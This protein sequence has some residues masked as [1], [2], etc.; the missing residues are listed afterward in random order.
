MLFN[1]REDE[2]KVN[3]SHFTCFTFQQ[4]LL[5]PK[6]ATDFRGSSQRNLFR[7]LS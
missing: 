3:L 7:Y 1:K 5:P 4:N 2:F 6:K